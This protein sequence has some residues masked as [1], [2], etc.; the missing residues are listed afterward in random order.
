MK[1]KILAAG[2]LLAFLLQ[3]C[4]QAEEEGNTSTIII[5]VDE[6]FTD[7]DID[8]ICH[9]YDLKITYDY[10]TLSMYALTTEK[11]VT[12]DELDQLIEDLSAEDGILLVEE[13]GTVQALDE[14][15]AEQE[16]I[17]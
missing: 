16:L 4:G 8:S 11:T 9:K 2:L 6:D 12:E 14:E 5:S 13:D 3:A 1:R 7:Q 15:E 10:D 17:D